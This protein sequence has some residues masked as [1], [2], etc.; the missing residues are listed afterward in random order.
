M[1]HEGEGYQGVWHHDGEVHEGVWHHVGRAMRV[2]GTMGK[3]GHVKVGAVMVTGDLDKHPWHA[4]P[5]EQG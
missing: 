5:H 4:E 2:Y 1:H 3:G